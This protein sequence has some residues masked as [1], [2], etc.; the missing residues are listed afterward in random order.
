MNVLVK[1]LI[2]KVFRILK[3]DLSYKHLKLKLRVSWW[4]Y[5]GAEYA[6]S[7]KAL[8]TNLI[9]CVIRERKADRAPYSDLAIQVNGILQV[10]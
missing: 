7:H 9:N 8:G 5:N 10:S 3:L 2:L 6:T 1:D 4:L